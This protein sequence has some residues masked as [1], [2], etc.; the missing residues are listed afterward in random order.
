MAIIKK[1][2][3]V[4]KNGGVFGKSKSYLNLNN[5]IPQDLEYLNLKSKNI[6]K[7]KYKTELENAE[8]ENKRILDEYN[9]KQQQ[10]ED[11]RLS[12][13]KIES[14]ES[15]ESQK[16][17]QKSSHYWFTFLSAAFWKFATFI[18]YIISIAGSIIKGVLKL[19]LLPVVYF[20]VAFVN[21]LIEIFFKLVDYFGSTFKES[22]MYFSSAIVY[23]LNSIGSFFKNF[24]STILE[25]G[26]FAHVMVTCLILAVIFGLVGYFSIESNNNKKEEPQPAVPPAVPQPT[27]GP[28]SSGG[29]LP[30][31]PLASE[32]EKYLNGNT[33]LYNIDF[34]E[35][36]S[37]PFKNLA[38]FF[39]KLPFILIDNIFPVHI[40][41]N[42]KSNGRIFLNFILESSG[43]PA[44]S[45]SYKESRE[46]NDGRNDDIYNIDIGLL[47]KRDLLTQL[48]GI[49][50]DN[51]YSI[52]K[53]KDI[54]W[55]F[56]ENYYKSNNYD[57]SKL[58]PSY[59]NKVDCDIDD[60]YKNKKTLLIPWKLDNSGSVYKINCDYI[61][62][63]NNDGS[64]ANILE[65]FDENTCKLKKTDHEIS[66]TVFQDK[67]VPN[68]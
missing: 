66:T 52:A 21:K 17:N 1:R 3:Y 63:S 36:W 41:N 68:T 64:T 58:P 25:R 53:P 45:E 22:V 33:E 2:K 11:E 28:A 16:L 26:P 29:T 13:K 39:S 50:N 60:S 40:Q 15:I 67:C 56:P 6:L 32:S 37:D 24:K 65:Y 51:I 62:F 8:K 30:D 61:Y 43:R 18:E 7:D 57:Y 55:K 12:D 34:S 46:K 44:L 42:I 59:V 20:I 23:I 14:L 31:D 19:V 38:N 47:N 54:I 35:F 27:G 10:L 48:N 49:P 9:I 4:K 5:F